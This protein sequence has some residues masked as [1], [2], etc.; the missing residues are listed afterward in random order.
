M[1]G[2]CTGTYSTL[3]RAF[4]STSGTLMDGPRSQ[5]ARPLITMALWHRQKAQPA[6]C[7]VRPYSA[8]R[9]E[10]RAPS[11]VS[12][13]AYILLDR[14]DYECRTSRNQVYPGPLL[15]TILSGLTCFLSMFSCAHLY[16]SSMHAQM[17]CVHSAF[18]RRGSQASSQ[19]IKSCRPKTLEILHPVMPSSPDY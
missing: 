16:A 19:L 9:L 4:K 14:C 12:P 6:I 13:I 5:V 18:A 3:T 17:S 10:N 7:C 15:R 2:G 8:A 11:I 1:P